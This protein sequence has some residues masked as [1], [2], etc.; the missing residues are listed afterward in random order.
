MADSPKV[1]ARSVSVRFESN[2]Q[3]TE[4]LRD[5][6]V[7]V[8]DGEFVILIGPSGCG[9]S[10]FLYVLGGFVSPTGGEVLI[11]GQPIS[12]PGRDRGVVF[13]QF[14]L[15]PWLTVAQNISLGLEL[16]RIPAL[17]RAG[18]IE[19]WLE[20]TG[21]AGFAGHFPRQLS[22]GMQ[23]RVAIARA[24]A[25]EPEVVLM[26][27]P[28][29]ALDAQTK[30]SMISDLQHIWSQARTTAVFVTHSVDE[31]ISLG[32]RIIVMTARPGQV[33]H[34]FFV[35]LDRPRVDT[36]PAFVALKRDILDA[37]AD[38]TERTLRMD[39]AAGR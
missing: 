35:D 20:I 14:A 17:E 34:E 8:D 29:G 21:L 39:S 11:D 37:L 12:G 16:R 19:R 36:D 6:T 5:V 32:D 3:G 13:Q 23:Q 4:A 38:E 28:F 7:A 24:L 1:M 15:Y 26:D 25:A 22:G 33:K 27:E 30:R 2:G 9:K 10:T 18:R 31:A